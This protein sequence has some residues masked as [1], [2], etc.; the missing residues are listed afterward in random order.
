MYDCVTR[1]YCLPMQIIYSCFVSKVHKM[2]AVNVTWEK[3]FKPSLT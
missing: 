1:V 2:S 3:A